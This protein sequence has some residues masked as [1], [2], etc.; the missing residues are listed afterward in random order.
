M[1][2]LTDCLTGNVD[3]V[4][5]ALE[6]GEGV[7][8]RESR[9]AYDSE[10][11]TCLLVAAWKGHEEVVSLLLERGAAVNAVDTLQRTALHCAWIIGGPGVLRILLAQPGVECNPRSSDGWTP[12]MMAV[13]FGSVESVRVLAGDPRV[14]LDTRDSIRRTL[15]EAARWG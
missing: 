2:L 11:R 8:T 3:G 6:S 5:A 14:E 10:G 13:E 7:D 12:V 1:G 15:E 4:R 9:H